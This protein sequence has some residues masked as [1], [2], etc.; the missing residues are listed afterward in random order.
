MCHV[1]TAVV[2]R[3]VCIALRLSQAPP[4]AASP[5]SQ[6]S[7]PAPSPP[8]GSAPRQAGSAPRQPSRI[9]IP[10][11][12]VQTA[13]CRARERERKAT[14]H[15]G[16]YYLLCSLLDPR[17]A[18]GLFATTH[19][20]R[21]RHPRS[22]THTHKSLTQ[23][24][25]SSSHTWCG[26]GCSGKV[27]RRTPSGSASAHV[28]LYSATSPGNSSC[29]RSER[30]AWCKRAAIPKRVLHYPYIHPVIRFA[31]NNIHARV[32]IFMPCITCGN[33]HLTPVVKLVDELGHVL[34]LC[35]QHLRSRCAGGQ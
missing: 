16:E 17:P 19:R 12:A 23:C 5:P 21:H 9:R 30:P 28:P 31:H 33:H 8:P 13:T 3:S 1:Y 15:S 32:H 18:L 7:A 25:P 26:L 24:A 14:L 35:L 4:T 10:R 6:P 22:H 20:H 11:G 2:F 27:T 29:S 34:E